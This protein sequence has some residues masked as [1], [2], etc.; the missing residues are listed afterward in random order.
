MEH[1]PPKEEETY[2]ET[3]IKGRNRKGCAKLLQNFGSS[4][5]SR[6][7]APRFYH[8]QVDLKRYCCQRWATSITRLLPNWKTRNGRVARTPSPKEVWPSKLTP[9]RR[10]RNVW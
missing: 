8:T 1:L 6:P 5:P 7:D 4:A 2:G 10:S 3:A 9:Y